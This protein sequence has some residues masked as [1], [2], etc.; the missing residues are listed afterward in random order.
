MRTRAIILKKQNANEYD[1]LVSCYTEELGKVTAIAKSVLKPNSIQAMHLDL[2]NLVDFDLINGRA[3]PIIT[4]TQ[5]EQTY[6][7]LKKD[8]P[9]LASAYFFA[10]V[11]DRLFFEYQK[12]EE[13]WN[14]F[15]ALL[16]ELN[17]EQVNVGE[18]LKTR[19]VE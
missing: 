18:F 5:A 6:L 12:D 1:Q 4:G 16:E 8:L 3:M 7:N 15:N 11:A 10:E 19:Q 13:L 9:R 2:F 14:F 17:S